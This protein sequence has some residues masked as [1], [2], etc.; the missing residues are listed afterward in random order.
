MIMAKI[1]TE[2][3]QLASETESPKKKAPVRN[4]FNLVGK[5]HNRESLESRFQTKIQIAV[6]GTENTAKTDTGKII[7]RT[8]ISSSIFQTDR[9]NRN[10]TAPTIS[11]EITSKNRHCLRGR[12][13]NYGKWDE[14]LRDVLNGKLRI[15]QNK[16][17]ETDAENEDDTSGRHGRYV[18]IQIDPENDV[19][20]IHTDGEITQG[21]ETSDKMR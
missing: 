12:D 2:E 1:E 19:I 13:R 14:I 10:T 5:N 20:Q 21:E 8:V 16:K 15:I 7:H 17:T 6:S 4:P 11:A 9:K 3:R 18:P